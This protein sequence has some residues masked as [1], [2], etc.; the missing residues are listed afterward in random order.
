MPTKKATTKQPKD[1][2][3]QDLVDAISDLSSRLDALAP[4]AE[5]ADHLNEY[6]N[7]PHH[8][9]TSGIPICLQDIAPFTR[10]ELSKAV[11][12]ALHDDRGEIVISVKNPDN[13]SDCVF[14][15]GVYGEDN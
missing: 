9:E 6:L 13:D 8:T 1:A 10:S 4:I 7:D 11:Y 2:T 15:V 12:E 3:I 5:L 14:S